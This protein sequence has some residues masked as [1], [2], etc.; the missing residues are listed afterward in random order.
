MWFLHSPER[1]KAEVSGIEDLQSDVSWLSDVTPRV[2]KG[3]RFAIDF[4]LLVNAE[5]LPFTLS[6]PTLF[7]ETPPSVLPRDGRHYSS[8]QWG[9]GGELCLE[10]RPDNW[11]PSVTGA[12][13]V[14]SAHRLLSAEQPTHEAPAVVPSAH[15]PSLGQELRGV[16]GRALLTSDLLHHISAL[17]PESACLCHVVDTLG[18]RQ[19]WTAFVASTGPVAAPT[20]QERTIPVRNN[21][22]TPGLLIRLSSLDGLSVSDHEDLESIIANVSAHGEELQKDEST[23]RFIVLA[24]GTTAHFYCSFF[25]KGTWKVMPYRTIDLSGDTTARLPNSYAAL[26]GQSVAVVGCGSLGS[27]IATSLARSGVRRFLLV[28]DDILVPANLVRNDL[29]AEASRHNKIVIIRILCYSQAP[30]KTY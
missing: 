3:L 6:Y 12:M 24:D 14:E 18:P 22:R 10:Y 25:H 19:N 2:L 21:Q 29:G 28:D 15:Q 30:W 4:D 20:W 9:S 1:L 7:P 17:P 26:A 27:K 13:M 16:T 23:S 5:R 8:H 11:D